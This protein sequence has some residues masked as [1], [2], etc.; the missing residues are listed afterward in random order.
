[1]MP[2]EPSAKHWNE[3]AAPINVLLSITQMSL[4]KGLRDSFNVNEELLTGL[5]LERKNEK[6]VPFRTIGNETLLVA[7]HRIKT[8]KSHL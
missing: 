2:G 3:L 8:I 4:M 7:L 1:M 6:V 5:K